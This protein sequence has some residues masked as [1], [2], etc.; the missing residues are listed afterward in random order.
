ME[1]VTLYNGVKKP[2]LSFGVLLIPEETFEQ[3]VFDAL[4]AGYR[5]FDT[6]QAYGNEHLLGSALKKSGIPREELFITTKVR[7]HHY[8][9]KTRQTVLESMEKLQVDYL[10]LVLLHQ[11]FGDIYAAWRDLEALYEEGKIRAIGVANFYADRLVDLAYLAKI[12]PMVDQVEV[13]PLHQREDMLH[14]GN[15]LGIAIE[16]WSPFGRGRG[17][18][19]ENPV[20]T[21]IGQKYGKTTA[22][23][24]LRWLLQ[25]GIPSV[26]KSAKT[27]R[28][29]QNIDVL[30]FALTEAEMET[31]A[32][33]ETGT[34]VFYSHEDP[35]TVE[36]FVQG[37]INS[38]A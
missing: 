34:S 30:D 21:G 35:Q 37:I 18:M 3:C 14:W 4:E 2:M 7:P 33:M 10:D 28:I 19:L 20:L 17:G 38:K 32:A 12:R 5:A 13:H 22:Q 31:V 1:Y 36:K 16:A 24:I 29:Y 25:R 23:V 15:K 8:D 27:E 9:G 6:A 11:P 26:A